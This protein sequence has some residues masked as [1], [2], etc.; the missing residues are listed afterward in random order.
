MQTDT[1]VAAHARDAQF[2]LACA[3]HARGNLQ[4]AEAA[5]NRILGLD[6]EYA[7]AYHKLGEVMLERGL[8]EEAVRYN[9]RSLELNPNNADLRIRNNLLKDL[10]KKAESA[11]I[12]S[13]R[14]Q[15]ASDRVIPEN[16]D[17]KINLNLQMRI[18]CH[19]SGWNYALQALEQIHNSQGVMFDGFLEDNFAWKHW[20]PAKRDPGILKQLE[21]A[22]VFRQL[23]TSEERGIIPY[24]KPWVG[25]VHN[26]QGMPEWF[27]YQFAPQTIF[28]K[29]VWKESL[30][31]CKGFFAF[32][33]YHADWLREQTGKP[34]SAL[35][36]P[37]EIPDAQFEIDRFL[38]NPHKQVVQVGWW[39][40]R[41]SAI[42]QLPLSRDNAL[43]YQKLRLVPMFS[44]DADVRLRNFI[45]KEMDVFGLT[46]PDAYMEN[47]KE[48]FHLSN[49]DYDQ[50]L[51]SNIVFLY[52]YDS[53]A[54]NAVIEC[55]ARATPLLVNPIPAVVEY[56]G[57]SYPLY[58]S[59]LHEAA[60]K[61][62]D[63][64]L[65]E[66]AHEYLKV[67]PVR[68]K[69]SQEYFLQS[70]IRSQVYQTL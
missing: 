44:D 51:S 5:L 49:N 67:C 26:P 1:R 63:V 32:S 27:H 6:P 2:S 34:V 43:K 7:P 53:S 41:L 69:L 31:Y 17:G 45:E 13:I 30:E 64:S 66:D 36:H 29:P 16:P 3:W 62:L 28:E 18:P 37:T 25:C 14:A 70:F 65:I 60:E 42:Y 4:A 11:G 9:N 20:L 21:Q 55:I 54:N 33:H 15:L 8:A 56:L 50:L 39:L 57:A 40:R 12:D 48:E 24:K 68:A 35:V 58:F 52:L 47:T 38:A 23:A 46:I 22:G 59:D 61:A 19:R 10:L